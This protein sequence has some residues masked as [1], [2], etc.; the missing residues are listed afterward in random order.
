MMYGDSFREKVDKYMADHIAQ[1]NQSLEQWDAYN[2]HDPLYQMTIKDLTEAVMNSYDLTMQIMKL[3]INHWFDFMVYYSMNYS[4]PENR[5]W[6]DMK[7]L[8]DSRMIKMYALKEIEKMC[9]DFQ[10]RGINVQPL[11]KVQN[12]CFGYNNT[13]APGA[14]RGEVLAAMPGNYE[15]EKDKYEYFFT[16]GKN[17]YHRTENDHYA[18]VRASGLIDLLLRA[19]WMNQTLTL[20][21]LQW[22]FCLWFI[23][24]AKWNPASN[25]NQ[26]DRY[27]PLGV[28]Q[29]PFGNN[30]HIKELEQIFR[31]HETVDAY[32][33]IMAIMP[34]LVDT[35]CK[36]YQYLEVMEG[37]ARGIWRAKNNLSKK[38]KKS[39]I[40][41]HLEKWRDRAYA[42]KPV[43]AFYQEGIA[44][45]LREYP[46]FKDFGKALNQSVGR[47]TR[48][49]D[50]L[51]GKIA[52][53]YGI[54][55]SVILEQ[56]K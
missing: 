37:E 49:C 51:C 5:N 47:F 7:S 3:S 11:K 42:L 38:E 31:E 33:K 45:I 18:M 35:V 40:Q 48:A 9:E 25:H 17:R 15:S 21:T 8:F 50:G 26:I 10:E 6:R 12:A 34:D 28:P 52:D 14:L 4:A 41:E 1:F 32:Q 27:T 53:E 13:Q 46:E 54:M 16:G 22:S 23:E 43:V 44:K 56:K 39:R 30:N 20:D 36:G 2:Q 19:E 29:F 55:Y 24:Y